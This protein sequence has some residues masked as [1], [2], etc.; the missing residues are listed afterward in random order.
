MAESE[1]FLRQQI[2]IDG[3]WFD[4][5]TRETI[6]VTNPATGEVIGTVPNAGAAE[7]R[8]AIEAAHRTFQSFSRTTAEERAAKL[9]I[10]HGLLVEHQEALA[11][12]LT[13][14]QG[15]PLREA[16][17]EIAMSA[18]YILWFSE[19][20]RRQY[21]DI[22]ESPW[23]NRQLQVIHAPV[24]VVAAITPWNFPSSMLARKIGPALAAGCTL[25]IKPAT[26]TPYSALAWA[27]LCERAGFPAGAVNILTGSATAI[28]GEL[29]GNGLVRKVTFT[30]S[31]G[32]GKQ[33]LAQCAA[34]VKRVSMELGGNAPFIVFDDANLDRAVEGAIAS[35]F[36]NSGQTCVCTNRIYVQSGIHDAFLDKLSA[37]VAELKIGQGLDEEV[38]FG[39]LIDAKAVASTEAFVQDAVAKGG[40]LVAGGKGLGG[41]FFA[42]TIIGNATSDMLFAKDEIFGP[43][44]PIFTFETEDESLALANDTE[45]GL[46][47]YVYTSSL[48]RAHRAAQSL[49]YGIVGINDGL[50]TTEVAPFGGFKQSGVGREGS[51]YGMQDYLETKYVSFGA[52]DE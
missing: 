50:I 25:V 15:K 18:K 4:A 2:H 1:T 51:K 13:L 42:P 16:R 7:T 34:S 43:V 33:L 45:Y 39:P 17:G 49:E 22:I 47:C 11:R 36:R 10:L 6:D 14:E 8:R 32:V 37:A 41:N 30:G 20:A 44:A 48:G 46:A 28:G 21:G 12:L 29:T 24:G 52:L 9:R 40:R 38:D 35:K 23:P 19:E 31:T 26:Q 3:H 27:I 5:D